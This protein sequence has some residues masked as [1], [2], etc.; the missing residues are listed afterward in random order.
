MI[1]EKG[2]EKTANSIGR[3]TMDSSSDRNG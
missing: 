2:G 3:D 1:E